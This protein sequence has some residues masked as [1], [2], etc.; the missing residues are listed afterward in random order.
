[1]VAEPNKTTAK[2][3]YGPTVHFKGYD[4]N[5]ASSSSVDKEVRTALP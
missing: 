4:K 2:N 1:M 3:V 5:G